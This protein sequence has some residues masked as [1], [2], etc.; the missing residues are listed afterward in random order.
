MVNYKFGLKDV[1]HLSFI[2][3]AMVMFGLLGGKYYLRGDTQELELSSERFGRLSSETGW[4]GIYF[5]GQK[6]GYSESMTAHQ[7]STL[8]VTDRTYMTF[9]ML[10]RQQRVDSYTRAVTDDSLRL[11]SFVFSISSE[12][13]DFGVRGRVE[14]NELV[15]QITTAGETRDERV[16]LDGPPQLPSTVSLLLSEEEFEPGKRF[17]TTVF[18]P[19]SLANV[20][21]VVE[22]IGRESITHGGQ[23]VQVWHL[24]ENMLN[25]LVDT[26]V[27]DEGQML[28]ERSQM[29]YRVVLE[30]ERTAVSDSL[31]NRAVDINQLVSIKPDRPLPENDRIVRLKVRFNGV[32]QDT[33]GMRGGNQT[34][35]D[36]VLEVFSKMPDNVILRDSVP[37][38]IRESYT[39]PSAFIQSEHP[40][41]LALASEIVDLN[42]SAP[43][44]I[45]SILEWMSGNLEK[46]PTFSIPNT[47]EV[48]ERGSGDCNE[49]AVLFC[50]L[51]RAA[52]IPTRVA[53]GLVYLDGA[54]Y[55]H[56]WCE[57]YLGAWVPVDPIFE[58]F[59]ADAT[60]LRVLAGDMDRQVEILPLVGSLE[61]SVIEWE[62]ARGEI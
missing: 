12:E 34:Y 5:K 49:F 14:E 7:D 53:M 42:D 29:G 50:S 60:H 28:E 1:V 3:F 46:K 25:M 55:Y 13:S 23:E 44:R 40:R 62:T 30:D 48:L 35:R 36:N 58:Q 51:A 31:F 6:I 4:Y 56:A 41:L 59:P 26:Y 15:L 11:I 39:L 38:R 54:F 61:I 33:L 16:K 57:C 37:V 8:V 27:D 24:Q 32:G 2:A 9:A 43:A 22:V 45:N 52:G 17:S 21:L 18:D 19:G 10:G 20:P 47:L